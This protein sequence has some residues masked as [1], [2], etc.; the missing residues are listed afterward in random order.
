MSISSDTVYYGQ[1]TTRTVTNVLEVL[2]FD[3]NSLSQTCAPVNQLVTDVATLKDDI[4]LKADQSYTLVH[5][6]NTDLHTT[7][8][9][10]GLWN[11]AYAHSTT[12]HAPATAEENQNAYSK[13]C[14]GS[15]QISA[16]NKED[17][18][19]L[20]AGN[21]ITLTPNTST[22]SITIASTSSQYIHPTSSGNKHI[23][24]GGTSGNVLQWS[25][26]GTAQWG[27]EKYGDRI[28]TTTG[29]GE[30]YVATVEGITSLTAGV[31]FI[32]IPHVTPTKVNPTLNVNGLGVKNLRMRVSNST[33]T[34]TPLS[35]TNLIFANRPTRVMY[36]GVQWVIDIVRPNVTN[37]YGVL[38]IDKGGTGGDTAAEARSNLDVY[39]KSEVEALI[40]QAIANL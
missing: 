14:V 6:D 1:D 12:N 5:I 22:K 8:D 13:I 25:S 34:T 20:V 21:N 16:D 9:S 2:E 33:V 28:V 23:P 26:D 7:A 38:P 15:S 11:M 17:A 32:M 35:T 24:S 37:L 18:F 29:T 30:A 39:S 31:S 36:D 3:T 27:A 19:N 4:V 40:A 10:K